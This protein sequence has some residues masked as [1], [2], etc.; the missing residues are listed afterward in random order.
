LKANQDTALKVGRENSVPNNAQAAIEEKSKKPAEPSLLWP[1]FKTFK[2]HVIG[3]FWLKFGYD[4]LQ[5]V[6][7][8]LL[9]YSIFAYFRN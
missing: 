9:K 2:S 7:P 5:F 6:S 8:L 3:G 4:C 1:L